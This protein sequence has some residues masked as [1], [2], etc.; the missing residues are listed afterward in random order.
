MLPRSSS[1]T[2]LL[3]SILT[4]THLHSS[5]Q[6]RTLGCLAKDS[7]LQIRNGQ[8]SSSLELSLCVSSW[9]PRW[10]NVSLYVDIDSDQ[11]TVYSR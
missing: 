8:L 3:P 6:R 11:L 1:P 5:P 7:V 10:V 4:L 2:P 9:T